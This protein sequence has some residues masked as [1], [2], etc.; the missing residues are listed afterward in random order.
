MIEYYAH[1]ISIACPEI[2]NIIKT[3]CKD[4]AKLEESEVT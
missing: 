4:R 3:F 2:Q 1:S